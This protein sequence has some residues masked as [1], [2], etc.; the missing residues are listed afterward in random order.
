MRP[1]DVREAKTRGLDLPELTALAAQGAS[2]R[3]VAGVLPTLTYPGGTA[4]IRLARPDDA[5]LTA[6]ARGVLA[7]TA[8]IRPIASTAAST[9]RRWP[10]PAARARPPSSSR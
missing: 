9:A 8:V 7:R 6:R 3:G 5:A 10:S 4:A 2:A 1:G